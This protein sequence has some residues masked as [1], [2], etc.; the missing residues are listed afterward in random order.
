MSTCSRRSRALL[1]LSAGALLLGAP[2]S[3]SAVE[4]SA[5]DACPDSM[6]PGVQSEGTAC[7]TGPV[8]VTDPSAAGAPTPEDPAKLATAEH[9]PLLG[10]LR[11]ETSVPNGPVVLVGGPAGAATATLAATASPLVSVPRG[12]GALP[13]T[14]AA[15]TLVAAMGALTA[16]LGVALHASA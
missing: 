5:V 2:A 8:V 13:F 12:A 4:P 15:T 14:G 6:N 9:D 10:E 7:I 11:V 1:L 3:S 16:L